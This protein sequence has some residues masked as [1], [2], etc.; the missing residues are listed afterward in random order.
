M[1]MSRQGRYAVLAACAAA[2]LAPGTATA[3]QG[4]DG[5]LPGGAPMRGLA[6][7]F[8]SEVPQ[9]AGTLSTAL[10]DDP[11]VVKDDEVRV[12]LAPELLGGAE[13]P[14]LG[15]AGRTVT[16]TMVPGALS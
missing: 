5:Q 8:A 15:P 12:P 16:G 11:H 13:L 10:P 6:R 1:G 2:V 4:S 3:V 14:L 7:V 9:L